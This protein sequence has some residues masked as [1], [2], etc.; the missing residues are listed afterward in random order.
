MLGIAFEGASDP[1]RIEDLFRKFELQKN[2][3][4]VK[5]KHIANYNGEDS[6]RFVDILYMM[7]LRIYYIIMR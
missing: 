4:D 7:K 2:I 1:I 3:T 6:E 5:L